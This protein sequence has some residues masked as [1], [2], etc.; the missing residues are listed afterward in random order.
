MYNWNRIFSHGELKYLLRIERD[1][2]LSHELIE[3]SDILMSDYL[4]EF[5]LNKQFKRYN[6]LCTKLVE[7]QLDYISSD[8]RY[9]VNKIEVVK[10][11]VE[12]L[13]KLIFSGNASDF[14]KN[15]VILQK[16]YGQPINLRLTSVKEYK[17]IESTYVETNK[18]GKR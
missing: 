7:L 17:N 3:A 6:K 14:D 16:W 8:K 9:L 5:G 10:K 15:H 13:S 12:E 1:V 4:R 11:E 2:K 18:K